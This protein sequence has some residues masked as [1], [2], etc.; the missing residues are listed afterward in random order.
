MILPQAMPDQRKRQADGGREENEIFRHLSAEPL[1]LRVVL[2]FSRAQGAVGSLRWR[3]FVGC[4][5]DVFVGGRLSLRR[6]GYRDPLAGSF[7]PS[8]GPLPFQALS[9]MFI[10]GCQFDQRFPYEKIEALARQSLAF[11]RLS[12]KLFGSPSAQFHGASLQLVPSCL[13]LVPIGA[14]FVHAPDCHGSKT[15]LLGRQR[16]DLSRLAPGRPRPARSRGAWRSR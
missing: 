1:L 15:Q 12:M 8:R 2:G 4:K 14:R 11:L 9:Q 3:G 7:S 16:Q 13:C 5:R 10:V 6:R